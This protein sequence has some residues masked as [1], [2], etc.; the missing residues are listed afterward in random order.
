L[1][2]FMGRKR[3]PQATEQ[4]APVGETERESEASKTIVATKVASSA[5]V[6]EPAEERTDAPVLDEPAPSA[7]GLPADPEPSAVATTVDE[8][9]GDGDSGRQTE[10][11]PAVD[12]GQQAALEKKKVVKKR[13][14]KKKTVKKVAPVASTKKKVAIVIGEPSK[15]PS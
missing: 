15:K 10:Q 3:K 14:T 11:Q 2:P 12:A 8:R 1:L 9:A 6:A 7:V 13:V 5:A 4:A